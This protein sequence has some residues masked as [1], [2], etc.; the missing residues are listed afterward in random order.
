MLVL[1]GQ[2]LEVKRYT[3]Y[4]AF[5]DAETILMM[6]K[7]FDNTFRQ[8]R[9]LFDS[10]PIIFS[11]SHGSVAPSL[12]VSSSFTSPFFALC[13][14]F[15]RIFLLLSPTQHVS[16]VWTKRGRHEWQQ[17]PSDYKYTHPVEIAYSIMKLARSVKPFLQG[18]F[19]APNAPES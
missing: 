10:R 16:S 2:R 3:S 7:T 19:A 1:Y 15:L 4:L 17:I 8:S 18:V 6:L 11:D 12:S 5:H 13:F 14:L 9:I